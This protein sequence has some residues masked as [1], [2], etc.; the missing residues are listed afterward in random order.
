MLTGELRAAVDGGGRRGVVLAVG[1]MGAAV[2]DVIG[3]DVDDACADLAGGR[4]E[5]A[6][7][8]AVD[9][10]AAFGVALGAIDGG[11]GGAI[12]DVGLA[13][14]ADKVGDGVTVAEV[15]FVDVGQGEGVVRVAVDAAADGVAQLAAGAGDEYGDHVE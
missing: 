9:L 12:D 10:E 14:A 1:A 4:G 13:T 11:V 5:V 3:G 6:D 7:G 15:E 2:E 8:V